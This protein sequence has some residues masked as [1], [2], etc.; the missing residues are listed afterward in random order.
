MSTEPAGGWQDSWP[1]RAAMLAA[2]GAGGYLIAMR[3]PPLLE[4]T[5]LTDFPIVATLL[6]LFAY[7]SVAH[8]LCN[9][10]ARLAAW[11]G[12]IRTAE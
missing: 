4:P 10:L 7:L 8:T 12:A 9:G 3:L 11:L 1:V 6:A 2:L 5:P